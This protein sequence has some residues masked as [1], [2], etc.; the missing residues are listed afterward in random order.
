MTETSP[1]PTV[2]AAPVIDK[3]NW[4]DAD[5]VRWSFQHVDQVLPTTPIS[6]GTGPVAQLPVDL[7]DLGSV[8]VPKTEFSAARSV[9]SVIEDSDTDAWMVMH[10]GTVVTEEYFSTMRPDTEHL[11]MSVSK[12]LVGTVAGVLVGAGDLDP[13]RLITDYVPE[14]AS[15]GYAG[16]T[17]RH[18]LD[19]RSGIKFSENYLDPKSE[20]RQIEES[21][22]WSESTPESRPKGMYEF[23]T[24]LEAKSEHGGVYEYRSCETDVLGWVC[25]KIAGESMQTLMSRVLWS[26]IGAERDALIAT[27]QYGV[28]MFDG[29]INTTLRDLARFGYLHAN[30]GV[31]LTGE[32]VAPTSWIGDTLTGDVDT[33]Q[34]FA[35]GPDDNR[36]PGGMY[37]NQFWFPFPDSHAF[38]ALGIHGQMIYMNPGANFVGV[39]LSSWGLPQ[40]AA[41]LFPTIRAFDAL[42]KAVSAPV[43]D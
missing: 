29:G 9:R 8:E 4:Q 14:L 37:R 11:L 17:V 27:D 28:G 36:M 3:D 21:I 31:S 19:M 18:I 33:R 39:K 1:D 22:G 6:R 20:V 41:K 42:A 13:N 7:Q 25:E 40:D 15:S 10:N 16:A 32:Q 24:T 43:V 2:P 5:N 26:R 34:A 23:L 38:L 12:S 35:D 30:R